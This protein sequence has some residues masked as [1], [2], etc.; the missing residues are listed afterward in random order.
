MTAKKLAETGP[1]FDHITKCFQRGGRSAIEVVFYE[2]LA[3]PSQVRISNSKS[4]IENV[5]SSLS[6]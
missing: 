2:E 3:S 4:V 1:S 5:I 6:K